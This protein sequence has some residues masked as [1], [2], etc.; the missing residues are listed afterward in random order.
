MTDESIGVRVQR[1][2]VADQTLVLASVASA[3]SKDGVFTGRAVTDLFFNTSLPAPE[4]VANVFSTLKKT[5]RVTSAKERGNWNLTPLGR[6]RVAELIGNDAAALI[7]ESL[8]G[9][10][11]LG[12][13]RHPLIPSSLAPPQLVSAVANFT[14]GSPSA[15]HVFGMT[16]FPDDQKEPHGPDPVAEA[17]E[18]TDGVLDGHGLRFLLA[19]QRAL[20]DDLWGNV[21]AHMW[22]SNY[23]IAFFEDRRGRGMNYNLVIEVGAMLMAGRRCLLLKDSSIKMMPTDLVGHIY[24]PVDLD[25]P[26]TIAGAV[27]EWAREDLAL[28]KCSDC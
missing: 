11:D 6:Q 12:H 17:L 14:K 16:R 1:M 3:R 7:A 10:A 19:S 25:A 5:G 9:G 18:I 13:L 4:K 20:V 26:A 8:P 23:G 28:G 21:Q 22:S 2:P 27:H 15:G 24:K